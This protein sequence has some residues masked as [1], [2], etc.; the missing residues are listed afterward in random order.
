MLPKTMSNMICIGRAAAVVY[1][2][3]IAIRTIAHI[4]RGSEMC[5]ALG[6]LFVFRS[7]AVGIFGVATGVRSVLFIIK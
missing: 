4:L 3:H 1:C 5:L 2:T 6:V 7:V